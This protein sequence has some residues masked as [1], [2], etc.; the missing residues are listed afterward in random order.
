[1][2]K[3]WPLKKKKKKKKKKNLLQVSPIVLT[4]CEFLK[5]DL[6]K[7]I[8]NDEITFITKILLFKIRGMSDKQENEAI[9]HFEYDI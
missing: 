1:M 3:V 2:L 5:V 7:S 8:R 4:Y 9:L 6:E